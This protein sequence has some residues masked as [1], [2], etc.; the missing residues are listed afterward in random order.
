MNG[1]PFECCLKSR[2]SSLF[3]PTGAC[4]T[5]QQG[6]CSYRKLQTH[7]KACMLP[8]LPSRTVAVRAISALFFSAAS[9]TIGICFR[10]AS[11]WFV[12]HAQMQCLPPGAP[13]QSSDPLDGIPLLLGHSRNTVVNRIHWYAV[14]WGSTRGR[15]AGPSCHAWNQCCQPRAVHRV[16]WSLRRSLQI[17][18]GGKCWIYHTHWMQRKEQSFGLKFKETTLFFF[19]FFQCLQIAEFSPN[20]ILHSPWA[21]QTSQQTL[22]LLFLARISRRKA[23]KSTLASWSPAALLHFKQTLR[24]R[25]GLTCGVHCPER[26]W[27]ARP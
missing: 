18:T 9:P 14:R 20:F 23:E 11:G 4:I 26:W 19:F 24:A 12:H 7:L 21:R 5:F 10:Q 6:I 22:I 2:G 13:A 15:S 1:F 17:L 16:I 8:L 27:K 3:S 25:G